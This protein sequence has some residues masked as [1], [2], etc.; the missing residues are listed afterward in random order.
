M[1][2]VRNEYSH[3]VLAVERGEVAVLI[4]SV[5]GKNKTILHFG[6]DLLV[7]DLKS[8]KIIFSDLENYIMIVLLRKRNR[9]FLLKS[10]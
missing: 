6:I 10:T 7:A 9:L 3:K 4:L 2:A 1:E 5:I 8:I